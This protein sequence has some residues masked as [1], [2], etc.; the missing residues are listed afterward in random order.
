MTHAD[1]LL[2]GIRKE[3]TICK[4][5]F[6]KLPD[7]ALPFKP[8]ENMRSTEEL[9]RYLLIAGGAMLRFFGM[10]QNRDNM[11]ASFGHYKEKLSGS[12]IVDFPKLMDDQMHDIEEFFKNISDEDLLTKQIMMPWGEFMALERGIIEGPIKWLTA[13]KMQ[14]F[15]YAKLAGN[16]KINT[17]DCWVGSEP[18]AIAG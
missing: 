16:S 10:E 9:L 12:E 1:N 5:L 11:K 7:G 2:E 8:A 3:I 15:L 14:L 18:E 17:G 13:Y 4:Q 6:K